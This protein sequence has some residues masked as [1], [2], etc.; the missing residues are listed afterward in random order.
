MVKILPN[1]EDWSEYNNSPHIEN[2]KYCG[3]E[4]EIGGEPNWEWWQYYICCSN[5]ICEHRY[6]D[7]STGWNIP[8]LI[9]KWNN[10]NERKND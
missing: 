10:K 4:A 9:E 8:E 6:S 1:M 2:C 5:P 3:A 7:K